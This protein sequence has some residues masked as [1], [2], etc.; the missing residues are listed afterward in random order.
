MTII[1]MDRDMVLK[2]PENENQKR[3]WEKWCPGSKVG[4]IINSPINPV[5][6]SK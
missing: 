6:Y 4:E 5:V 1:Y 3:D 2:N